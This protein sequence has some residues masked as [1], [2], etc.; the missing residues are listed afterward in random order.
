MKQPSTNPGGSEILIVGKL[1]PKNV[2]PGHVAVYIDG[3]WQVV[4]DTGRYTIGSMKTHRKVFGNA[5]RTGT[6]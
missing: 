4:Q 2:P 1:K 3:R 5:P 6:P